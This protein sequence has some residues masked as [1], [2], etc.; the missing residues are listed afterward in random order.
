MP[1]TLAIQWKRLGAE[2]A[3]IV[4]S[5]LLAFSID[6]WW[7]SK[8]NRENEIA[9]LDALMVDLNAFLVGLDWVD[10]HVRGMHDSA[11]KLLIAS[12]DGANNLEESEIDE[13]LYDLTFSVDPA[14]VRIPALEETSAGDAF[15]TVMGYEFRR[16]LG[17]FVTKLNS[18][19]GDILRD[20]KFFDEEFIP[21]LI[22]NAFLPQV[23]SASNRYPGHPGLEFPTDDFGSYF[24]RQS[25]RELLADRTFQGLLQHRITMFVDYVDVR[26]AGIREDTL[27]LIAMIEEELAK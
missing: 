5:I 8:Q 9:A 24:E 18:V 20:E 12:F 6:A 22:E 13:L 25:H 10:A 16:K 14:F 3:A 4:A 26:P 19:Q 7:E 11:R 23:Y 1:N 2:G 27:R 17:Q 21:F 15:S